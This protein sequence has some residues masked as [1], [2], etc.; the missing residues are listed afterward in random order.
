IAQL[1]AAGYDPELD[2]HRGA[3]RA[4]EKLEVLLTKHNKTWNDLPELLQQ[5][6]PATQQ[7]QDERAGSAP[8]GGRGG[9]RKGAGRRPDLPY[10]QAF[11]I[12]MICQERFRAEQDRQARERYEAHQATRAKRERQAIA[13]QKAERVAGRFKSLSK[14]E[15]TRALV[16]PSAAIDKLG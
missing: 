6:M 9:K 13:L 14:R 7:E 5:A 16:E 8:A 2:V 3:A 4:R 15:L 1:F 12:G 11:R 10:W